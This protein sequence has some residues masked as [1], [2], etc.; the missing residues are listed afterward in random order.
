MDDDTPIDR[1][2]DRKK[3]QSIDSEENDHIEHV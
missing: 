2:K 3:M 1:K